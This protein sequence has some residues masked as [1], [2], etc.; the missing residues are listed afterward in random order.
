MTTTESYLMYIDHVAYM[1]KRIRNYKCSY[2]AWHI[3][4]VEL[5][6]FK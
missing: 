3:A 2:G 5:G 1:R 4:A 6:W